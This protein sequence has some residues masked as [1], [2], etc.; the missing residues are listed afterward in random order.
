M[1]KKCTETFG[2][3]SFGRWSDGV[4]VCLSFV[5]ESSSDNWTIILTL[6][7]NKP[8]LGGSCYVMVTTLKKITRSKSNLEHTFR[9]EQKNNLSTAND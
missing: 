2:E 9:N 6:W 8:S 7:H 5:C 1:K 3:F 4:S